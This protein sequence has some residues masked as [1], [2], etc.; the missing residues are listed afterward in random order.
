MGR[1]EYVRKNIYDAIVSY[2]EQH[3]YAPSIDEIGKMVGL[4]SKASIHNHLDKMFNTGMI[5]SDAPPGSA[6]AI[7]VK[8]YEFTAS[9]KWIPTKKQQPRTYTDVLAD[10]RDYSMNNRGGLMIGYFVPNGLFYS[11]GVH[12][13][14]DGTTMKVV[15]WM[16]LPKK[17]EG[18]I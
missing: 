6:R 8:G 4:K 5:E 9:T 12:Y 13:A 1:G 16:P 14:V 3:G 18:V 10:V 7:R 17:Y 11:K 2:I 15:A